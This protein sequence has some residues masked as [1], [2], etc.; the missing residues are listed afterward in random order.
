MTFRGPWKDN[1]RPVVQRAIEAN[2]EN[3]KEAFRLLE[4]INSEFQSDPMSVQCFDL[5]MVE[6]VKACVEKKQA[7]DRRPWS[8]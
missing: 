2:F 5:R 7:W 3:E 8:L 1:I 6:R 4:L